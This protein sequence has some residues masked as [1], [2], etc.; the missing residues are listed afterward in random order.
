M[1]KNSIIGILITAIILTGLIIVMK[2]HKSE[3]ER[4]DDYRF[5]KTMYE[6]T[7]ENIRLDK[8]IHGH[9]KAEDLLRW[10]SLEFELMKY[11]Q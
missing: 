11:Q 2:N 9:A 6:L 3:K 7:R 8:E 10:D 4:L 1:N 5:T